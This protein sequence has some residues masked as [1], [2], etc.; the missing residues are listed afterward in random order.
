MGALPKTEITLLQ[1]F[2]SYVFK[3]A[4]SQFAVDK[5]LASCI[6]VSAGKTR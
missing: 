4:R 6:Y 5:E 2:P 3:I 1:K